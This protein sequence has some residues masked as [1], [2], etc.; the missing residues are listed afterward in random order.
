MKGYFLHMTLA[1]FPFFLAKI[2][3]KNKESCVVAK[4]YMRLCQNNF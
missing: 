1:H 2:G 4:F 3:D